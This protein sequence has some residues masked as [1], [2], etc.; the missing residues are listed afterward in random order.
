M[1]TSRLV[2]VYSLSSGCLHFLINGMQPLMNMVRNHFMQPLMVM[3][4][5]RLG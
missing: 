3:V 2:F 1:S 4:C 5:Y